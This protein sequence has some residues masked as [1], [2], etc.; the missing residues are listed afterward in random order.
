MKGLPI[1]SDRSG[2]GRGQPVPARELLKGILAA[3]GSKASRADLAKA[4]EQSLG[5]ERAP[6][7]RVLGF[8]RGRLTV[9]V[10]S[11]PLFAELFGFGT[12]ELRTSMNQLLTKKKIA[13]IDFRLGGTAN[14]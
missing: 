10:D 4:L 6:H 13:Q 2:S 5:P 1:E 3:V 7:C 11:A 12:E 14:V 9:E 8:H